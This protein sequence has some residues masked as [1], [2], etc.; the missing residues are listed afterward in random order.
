MDREE[1]LS[2]LREYTKNVNL[3]KHG[4][5]VEAAMRAYARKFG[6]DEEKWGIAGLLH[7]LDYEQFPDEHPLKGVEI[8][9]GRG[10]PFDLVHA[11]KAH[12]DRTG[13]PRET[14]L[15]K[16]LYAVDEL[17]GL[18]VAVALVRPSKS[19]SEVTVESVKKKWGAKAFAKG[20]DR[21]AIKKGAEELGVELDEHI[22]LVI[23]AMQGIADDL[24]L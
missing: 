11:V 9:E 13:V 19:L 10:A 12:A 1:A 8:L 3:V 18:I 20:V 16:A 2:L 7:D 17:T 23:R 6:E 24:G 14:K 15:D 21:A 4:L 5:A 22:D